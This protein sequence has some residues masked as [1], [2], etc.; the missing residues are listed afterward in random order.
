[1]SEKKDP[2]EFPAFSRQPL[3]TDEKELDTDTR[4]KLMQMRHR[5]L[6]TSLEGKSGFPSWVRLPIIGF[7]T[8]LIFISLVYLKPGLGPQTD[9][10]LEDL[11]ILISNDPIEFYEHLEFLQKWKGSQNDNKAP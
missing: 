11:E 9:K 5:E 4:E 8:A 7:V 6:E 3:R 1:M 10:G 2:D